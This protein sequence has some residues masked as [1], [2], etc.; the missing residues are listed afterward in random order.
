MLLSLTQE[1]CLCNLPLHSMPQHAFYAYVQGGRAECI[2]VQ[3]VG[4]VPDYD[5]CIATTCLIGFTC[6]SKVGWKC[7]W[8]AVQPSQTT[9]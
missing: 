1:L 8:A 7:G 4:G 6:V 3:T 5:P 2:D 9:A